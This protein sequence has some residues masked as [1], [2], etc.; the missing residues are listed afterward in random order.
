VDA[1][2]IDVQ[3]SVSDAWLE[4]V[5]LVMAVSRRIAFRVMLGRSEYAW[6]VCYKM[7]DVRFGGCFDMQVKEMRESTRE[8]L[9]R[10]C[11]PYIEHLTSC[12]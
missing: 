10:N 7:G 9:F 3:S 5:D 4:L 1:S 12:T 8:H 2:S 11:G 6:S